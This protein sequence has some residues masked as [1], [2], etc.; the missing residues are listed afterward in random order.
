MALAYSWQSRKQLDSSYVFRVSDVTTLLSA[1]VT[2]TEFVGRLWTGILAW[3]CTFILFE[4]VGISIEHLQTVTSFGIFPWKRPYKQEWA[5]V[6]I[7]LLILPQAFIRPLLSGSINWNFAVDYAAAIQFPTIQAANKSVN[8]G[9]YIGD[10]LRLRAPLQALGISAVLWSA[11]NSQTSKG[12]AS[13]ALGGATCRRF[14]PSSW[15]VNSTLIN[16]IVPCIQIHSITWPAQAVPDDLKSYE[17]GFEN[18]SNPLFEPGRAG[19][20]VLLNAT[21]PGWFPIPNTTDVFPAQTKWSDSATVV[22]YITRQNGP[23]SSFDTTPFGDSSYLFSH[24]P[25]NNPFGVWEAPNGDTSCFAYG[26]VNFTAGVMRAPESTFVSPGVIE[27]NPVAPR[28]G[29]AATEEEVAAAIE[30]SVWT[31]VALL[32]VPGLMTQIA[33]ANSSQLSAW[34]SIDNYTATL[35]RYAYFAAWNA[36]NSAFPEAEPDLEALTL[37]PAQPRLQASVSLYRVFTWLAI[38]LFI[39]ATGIILECV[40]KRYCDRKM[41]Q[42]TVSLLFTDASLVPKRNEEK[43]KNLFLEGDTDLKL[44]FQA[45]AL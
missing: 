39:P 27:Y 40:H 28:D 30:P 8:W 25:N 34:K 14:M 11:A 17:A 41:I 3:R 21:K 32:L 44:K 6:V 42:G 37:H 36:L 2:L 10:S 12:G 16:A 13:G 38:T 20:A 43:K 45:N 5:V 4:T 35:I 19:S 7:L 29:P 22:L 23:C 1:A 15:P 18:S 33:V 31:E 26:I 9:Y 24:L